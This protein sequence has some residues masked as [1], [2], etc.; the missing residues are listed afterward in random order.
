MFECILL[1]T[2]CFCVKRTMTTI[3]AMVE[4][5]ASTLLYTFFQDFLQEFGKKYISIHA[6]SFH[7]LSSR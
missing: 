2:K 6:Q 4:T 3:D 1:N 7:D 5:D